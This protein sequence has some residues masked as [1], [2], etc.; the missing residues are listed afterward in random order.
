M[1]TN[2]K[3]DSFESSLKDLE[4]IV[5][6]LERGESPLETQLKSFEKGIALSRDCLKQLE[7]VEKRVELLTRDSENKLITTPFTE[8]P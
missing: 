3:T 4:K 6:E 2:K 8:T 7:E 1:E 5:G